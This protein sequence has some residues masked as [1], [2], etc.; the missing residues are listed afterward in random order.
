MVT[1]VYLKNFNQRINVI[2]VLKPPPLVRVDNDI[3]K[4]VDDN[5]SVI[6]LLLELSAA[7][8]TVDHAILVSILANRFGIWDTA[9]NWFR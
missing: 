3:L 4:A 6:L 2:T 5:K 1:R 7:F 9:L 8:D